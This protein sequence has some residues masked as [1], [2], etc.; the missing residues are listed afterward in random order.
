[1]QNEVVGL[2]IDW[3]KTICIV[4]VVKHTQHNC[5]SLIENHLKCLT[6]IVN[7]VAPTVMSTLHCC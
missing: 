1:M 3:K 6:S 4:V 5:F 2:N 7:A